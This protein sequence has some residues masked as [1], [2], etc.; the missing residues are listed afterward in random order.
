MDIDRNEEEEEEAF[1]VTE[2]EILSKEADTVPLGKYN[3]VRKFIKNMWSDEKEQSGKLF[4]AGL[5]N[6][7]VGDIAIKALEKDKEA[8]KESNEIRDKN[9][10][11][12]RNLAQDKEV[13]AEERMAAMQHLADSEERFDEMQEAEGKKQIA[14]LGTILKY[15]L[16]GIGLVVAAGT[17]STLTNPKDEN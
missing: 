5:V 13:S 12:F 8:L 17:Y 2:S 4:V 7:K 10:A 6:D 3:S 15:G 1:E 11:V 16:T 14:K 9:M